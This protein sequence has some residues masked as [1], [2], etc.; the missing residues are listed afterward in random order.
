MEGQE[1]KLQEGFDN[2]YVSGF[3]K[4]Q[5]AAELKGFLTALMFSKNSDIVLSDNLKSAIENL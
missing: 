3:Q 4:S 5:H 1:Q 2:G